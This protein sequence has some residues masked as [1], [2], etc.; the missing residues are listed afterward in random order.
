MVVLSAE[1]WVGLWAA[2]WVLVLVKVMGALMVHKL[3]IL[4]AGVMVD[5]WVA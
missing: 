5:V 3:E 2:L 1:M 4:L